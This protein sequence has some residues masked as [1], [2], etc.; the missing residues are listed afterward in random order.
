MSSD[1]RTSSLQLLPLIDASGAV[2]AAG[3]RTH[4]AQCMA[5]RS[6]VRVSLPAPRSADASSTSSPNAPLETAHTRP[7]RVQACRRRTTSTCSSS[8]TASSSPSSRFSAPLRTSSTR[9]RAPSTP[10][11]RFHLQRTLAVA[12]HLVALLCMPPSQPCASAAP[13]PSLRQSW[14][15]GPC[16]S[17][18]PA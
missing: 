2:E 16:N 14:D 9:T 10:P 11:V 3:T 13:P 15:H 6:T 12:G 5:P 18:T 17:R 1:Q 8:S 7:K 4:L